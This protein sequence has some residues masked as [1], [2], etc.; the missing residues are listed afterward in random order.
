MVHVAQL[1]R[2]SACEVDRCGFESRHAPHFMYQIP[3]NYKQWSGTWEPRYNIA[4]PDYPFHFT[5]E[6]FEA[7]KAGAEYRYQ[8]SRNRNL[9]RVARQNDEHRELKG[10]V[11]EAGFQ[12]VMG[13]EL[14][15]DVGKFVEP[16]FHECEIRATNYVMGKLT[17]RESD[18]KKQHRPYI[19]MWVDP[20]TGH[21]LGPVGW[22]T[23]AEV[24]AKGHKSNPYGKGEKWDA[25]LDELRPFDT[26]DPKLYGKPAGYKLPADTQK[27]LDDRLP[28]LREFSR[29]F[30]K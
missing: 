3:Q 15:I 29:Q 6:A 13:E 11:G 2:V 17:V 30:N 24:F 7:I 23:A 16:D 26:L 22:L 1:V 4:Y 14:C 9:V 28:I 25:W 10:A 20:T 12:C 5:P 19:L 18:R 8:D 21:F 27:H